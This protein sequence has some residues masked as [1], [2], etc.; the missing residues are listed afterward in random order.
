[1]H[2]SRRLDVRVQGLAVGREGPAKVTVPSWWEKSGLVP[3]T[4]SNADARH[5]VVITIQP[6]A[7][8]AIASA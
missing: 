8:F 4:P 1:M 5:L 3:A 2:D 6:A 7:M